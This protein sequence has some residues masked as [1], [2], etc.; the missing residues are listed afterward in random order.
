M[1]KYFN[2]LN[3]VFRKVFHLPETKLTLKIIKYRNEFLSSHKKQFTN[4]YT[5]QD[6]ILNS[7]IKID[8]NIKLKFRKLVAIK[9]FALLCYET[10][11]H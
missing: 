4:N 10:I 9:D 6:I 8:V 1:L 3:K 5:S 2:K 11:C 7:E